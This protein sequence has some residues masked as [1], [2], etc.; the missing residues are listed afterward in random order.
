MIEVI[1]ISLFIK[2]LNENFLFCKK[3]FIYVFIFD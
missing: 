3:K 2:Y 1:K